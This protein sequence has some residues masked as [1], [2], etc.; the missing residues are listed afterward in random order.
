MRVRS[1]VYSSCFW[2]Q[3]IERAAGSEVT[4]RPASTTEWTSKSV[5]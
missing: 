3:S 2:R 4:A 5:P 1:Q